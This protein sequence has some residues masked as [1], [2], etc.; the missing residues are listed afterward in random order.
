MSEENPGWK[1]GNFN[2]SWSSQS[3]YNATVPYD[4]VRIWGT[5][6]DHRELFREH[7]LGLM[8]VWETLRE[9]FGWEVLLF[10][11]SSRIFYNF[12]MPIKYS[13]I[14]SFKFYRVIDDAHL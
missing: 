11:C 1:K 3:L 8:S 10:E 14:P 6:F 7:L 9:Y 5:A 4:S 12:C 13:Q 2:L